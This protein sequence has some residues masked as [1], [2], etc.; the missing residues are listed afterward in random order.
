[1]FFV[2]VVFLAAGSSSRMSYPKQLLINDDETLSKITLNIYLKSRCSEII[3][4][5]GGNCDDVYKALHDRQAA[6]SAPRI[7]YIK[8]EDFLCGIGTSIS[9]GIS[10]LDLKSSH[11]L[12]A[13]A[14]MP[15]VSVLTV[16]KLIEAA[17][18]HKNSIIAPFFKGSR[19]NP[20]IF[21]RSFYPCLSALGE[22]TGGSSIIGAHCDKLIQVGVDDAGILKDIDTRSDWESFVEGGS[23]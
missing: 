13:L 21:P 1:M 5:L 22:D 11:C 18:A 9:K 23:L 3:I 19:G 7:K 15:Y 20:V 6:N 4:V 12:I 2:S 10:G 17:K 14:D 8:N 16:D